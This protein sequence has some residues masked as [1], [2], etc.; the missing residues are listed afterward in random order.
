MLLNVAAGKNT[1]RD[2]RGGK[3]YFLCA[4]KF[5]EGFSW[6]RE[7]QK[8]LLR[9][10]AERGLIGWT[11][12]PT[13]NGFRR[14]RYLQIDVAAVEALAAAPGVETTPGR[15][16]NHPRQGSKPPPNKMECTCTTYTE[17]EMDEDGGGLPQTGARASP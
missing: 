12:R 4:V 10:L 11:T 2:V 3:M 15:G 9:R 13:G 17:D 16:Q 8:R 14:P 7:A 5:L 1:V 6:G